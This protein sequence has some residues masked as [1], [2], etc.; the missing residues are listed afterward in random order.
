MYDQ[1]FD[2]TGLC[3]EGSRRVIE[4]GRSETDPGLKRSIFNVGGRIRIE[5]EC[6]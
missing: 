4:D 6:L 3:T 5:I 2:V 1:G